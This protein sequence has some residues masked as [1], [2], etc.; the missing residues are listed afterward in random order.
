MPA[1]LRSSGLVKPA[2]PVSTKNLPNWS[3]ATCPCPVFEQARYKRDRGSPTD[4]SVESV[5]RGSWEFSGTQKTMAGP[6]RARASPLEP[7]RPHS[8][9]PTPPPRTGARVVLLGQGAGGTGPIVSE[10]G[11]ARNGDRAHTGGPYARARE[12]ARAD[13]TP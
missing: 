3:S 12:P 7:T 2:K 8:W 1:A 4:G 9:A 11:P 10:G 6:T 5:V 13:A